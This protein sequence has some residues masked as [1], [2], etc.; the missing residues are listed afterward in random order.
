MFGDMNQTFKLRRMAL[1]LAAENVDSI[2][3]TDVVKDL[4]KQ[5]PEL[6]WEVMKSL[7]KK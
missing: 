2:I 1:S 7:N 3:D 4:F 6:A 5:Q